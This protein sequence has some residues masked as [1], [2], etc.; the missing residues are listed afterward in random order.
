MKISVVAG[1]FH[2]R[3]RRNDTRSSFHGMTGTRLKRPT[4]FGKGSPNGEKGGSNDLGFTVIPISHSCHSDRIPRSKVVLSHSGRKGTF[5]MTS[6]RCRNEGRGGA[7]VG[8][9][10]PQKTIIPASFYPHFD[11]TRNSQ[12]SERTKQHKKMLEW[13]QNDRNYQNE[14]LPRSAIILTSFNHF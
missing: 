12:I 11:P 9:F 14:H 1:S 10:P 3:T 6:E 4:L 7:E 5:R 2:F 13:P 8:C